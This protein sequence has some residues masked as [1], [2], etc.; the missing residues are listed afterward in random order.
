[1]IF[2]IL[3]KWVNVYGPYYKIVSKSLNIIK[4]AHELLLDI[5]IGDPQSYNSVNFIDY[6]KRIINSFS[7]GEKIRR[8]RNLLFNF[9]GFS[10]F[11]LISV[12]KYFHPYSFDP[13]FEYVII[14]VIW[15]TLLNLSSYSKMTILY[16]LLISIIVQFTYRIY[17]KVK[18]RNASFIQQ[19]I[20][21]DGGLIDCVLRFSIIWNDLEIWDKNDLD[22]HAIEP[23]GNEIYFGNKENKKTDGMLDVDVTHPYENKVACENITWTDT[24]KMEIG[25][26]RFFVHQ[27]A[28]RDGESGF[29]A[30]VEFGGLVYNY[31]YRKVLQQSEDVDVAYITL[32][33][34]IFSIEHS[35]ECKEIRDK[36][37]NKIV[38]PDSSSNFITIFLQQ[39]QSAIVVIKENLLQFWKRLQNNDVHFD[40]S[41]YFDGN[42]QQT[43]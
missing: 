40:A 22:A 3:Y 43:K 14:S 30:E 34:G 7:T 24:D 37:T 10:V 1:M 31:E 19:H 11:K 9:L 20:V 2:L 36:K 23:E 27:F 5:I 17:I 12:I 18:Y 32:E 26:Y 29:R 42:N 28:F 6:I 15:T 21:E 41:A 16:I 8:H 39:L 4:K 33:N 38:D 35:L 13:L 25:K